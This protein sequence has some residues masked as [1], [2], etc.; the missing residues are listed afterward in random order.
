MALSAN[1]SRCSVATIIG[2]HLANVCCYLCMC[3]CV[4]RVGWPAANVAAKTRRQHQRPSMNVCVECCAC[5]TVCCFNAHRAEEPLVDG[6]ITVPMTFVS[7]FTSAVSK[8]HTNTNTHTQ[9]QITH[10]RKSK[11]KPRVCSS[12]DSK[13]S[14]KV[15]TYFIH[16]H[17][18]LSSYTS[19]FMVSTRM[20]C[21][22]RCLFQSF[23]LVSHLCISLYFVYRAASTC[24]VCLYI[25]I[26]CAFRV[27]R[28]TAHCLFYYYY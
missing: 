15:P 22:I 26:C 28:P 8:H 13:T 24:F 25:Q 18:Y 11:E 23:T 3:V 27:G 1:S 12:L 4:C 20:P 9:A 7:Y 19:L 14:C 2:K 10:R 21:F 6:S 5:N 17:L 16:T